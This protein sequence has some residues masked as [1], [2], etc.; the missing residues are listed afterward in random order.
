MAVQLLGYA[1]EEAFLTDPDHS[2]RA[3]PWTADEWGAL[4]DTTRRE[5]H[6]ELKAA[7]RRHPPPYRRAVPGLAAA[8]LF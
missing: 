3:P 7:I 2:L 5:G 1:S 8:H 6:H 4:R